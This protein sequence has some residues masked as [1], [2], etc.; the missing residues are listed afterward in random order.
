LRVHFG[1]GRETSIAK[2][3]VQWINGDTVSYSIDRV[4]TLLTVDQK[5]GRVS[6]GR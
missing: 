6:Y 3:E 4:D 5:S 1:L 2:F